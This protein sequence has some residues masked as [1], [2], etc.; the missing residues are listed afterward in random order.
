MKRRACADWFLVS[1]TA[2]LTLAW[3]AEA[4]A[5]P[6]GPDQRPSMTTSPPRLVTAKGRRR[7]G[8]DRTYMMPVLGQSTHTIMLSGRDMPAPTDTAVKSR[9]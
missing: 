1:L 8:P 3:G 2:A 5:A 9:H 4:A 7:G 6:S